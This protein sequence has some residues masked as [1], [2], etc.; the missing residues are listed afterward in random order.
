MALL[1]ILAVGLHIYIFPSKVISRHTGFIKA[2][3]GAWRFQ[4]YELLITEIFRL[5]RF[6][7]FAVMQ[8]TPFL[9]SSQFT[10]PFS[11]AHVLD[12]H[13]D[14][15][16]EEF[17]PVSLLSRALL[18]PITLAAPFLPCLPC[19]CCNCYLSTLLPP[20]E[21]S[22][23]QEFSYRKAQFV[24]PTVSVTVRCSRHSHPFF[25]PLCLS[26]EREECLQFTS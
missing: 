24:G 10:L 2:G 23:P 5:M 13:F 25:V 6:P 4:Q 16:C 15:W 3:G 14:L 8:V 18:M 9:P 26:L 21:W 20:A 7:F 11:S 1:H 19:F 12:A 22:F 17:P